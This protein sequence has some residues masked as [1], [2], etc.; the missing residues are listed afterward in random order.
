[1]ATK[2]Q[3]LCMRQWH[4]VRG[5]MYL[6][7]FAGFTGGIGMAATAVNAYYNV[8]NDLHEQQRKMVMGC[9]L[10][11]VNGAMTVFVLE[12]EKLKC[13]RWK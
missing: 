5:W 13:W 11:D 12:D 6:A 7:A 9:N 1:M 3:N 8:P 10:P 2:I 4:V